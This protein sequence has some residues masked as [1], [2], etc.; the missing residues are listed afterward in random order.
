MCSFNDNGKYWV[1]IPISYIPEFEQLLNTKSIIL[2]FPA[3]GT[4]G[5]ALP[6]DKMSRRDPRPP[7]KIIAKVFILKS[8]TS[9]F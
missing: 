7:A 3:K 1:K 9:I 2:N 6:S 4:L 5:L 8:P